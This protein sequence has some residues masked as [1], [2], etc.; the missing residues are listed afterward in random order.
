MTGLNGG[1]RDLEGKTEMNQDRSTPV[2]WLR[3]IEQV[4]NSR[5]SHW[6]S[7]FLHSPIRSNWAEIERQLEATPFRI[8][9]RLPS[10]N[11]AEVESVIPF[12]RM[13]YHRCLILGTESEGY[14]S[15][16]SWCCMLCGAGYFY[17]YRHHLHP[18]RLKMVRI[19]RPRRL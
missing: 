14:H 5:T 1:V 10:A 4:D 9:P 8:T 7:P 2:K 12:G 3:E 11:S 13:S 15:V 19:S 17:Q 18:E 6:C 16:S